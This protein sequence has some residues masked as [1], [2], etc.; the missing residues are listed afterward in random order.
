MTHSLVTR[1]NTMKRRDFIVRG[2]T[3]TAALG[4]S[5]CSVMGGK[6]ITLERMSADHSFE[7]TQPKPPSGTM[8]KGEL[9]TSGIEVSNFGFGA[10]LARAVIPFEK[11]REKMIH[12]AYDHGIT[13]FDVYDHAYSQWEPMSRHLAPMLNDVVISLN[14]VPK[15][16]VTCEQEIERGLRVF[17]RDYIDMWRTNSWD[18]TNAGDE[19]PSGRQW[20]W[21]D[22]LIKYKEKG[23]IR[24]IGCAIH[25]PQDIEHVLEQIPID[26]AIFPFN[27]YHNLL[28]KGTSAGSFDPLAEKLREKGIGMVAM[29]PFG[30]D[31]YVKPLIEAAKQLDETGEISLTQSMLRWIIDSDLNPD[32]ILGGMFRLDHVYENI[33]AFYHPEITDEEK[34]LLR[35]LRRV[36]EIASAGWLPEYYRFL[37]TWAPGS[38][39]R[40][41]AE[42]HG[43]PRHSTSP[44]VS[45]SI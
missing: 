20:D 21:W 9:G 30:T 38:A 13:T 36:T 28:H 26:Y 8:P 3:G 4:L 29:K 15:S 33:P 1:G 14:M 19:F 41:F 12:E 25:T 42:R 7:V 40:R 39:P 37:D 18:P 43:L 5:G 16:G 11:E 35:K 22:T 31:W 45:P 2:A 27:F 10:H 44:R 32:I 23:H 17:K 24:A 34:E 6:K